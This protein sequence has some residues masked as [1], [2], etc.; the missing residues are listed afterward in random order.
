MGRSTAGGSARPARRYDAADAPARALVQIVAPPVARRGGDRLAGPGLDRAAAGRPG[1]PAPWRRPPASRGR[2]RPLAGRAAPVHDGPARGTARGGVALLLLPADRGPGAGALLRPAVHRALPGLD[3]GGGPWPVGRRAAPGPQRSRAGRAHDRAGAVRLPAGHRPAHGQRER[4]VPGG[5]RPGP[6]GDPGGAPGRN[7][8][9]RRH[10]GRR[11]R[12]RHGDRGQDPPGV[13][14]AVAP[15]PGGPRGSLR[16]LLEDPGGGGGRRAVPPGRERGH[17]GDRPMGGLPRL[18][19]G[20]RGRRGHR[21]PAQRRAGLPAGAAAGP[22]RRG[23]AIAARRRCHRRAR[24]DRRRRPPDP[25]SRRELRLGHRGVPRRPPRHLVPLPGAADPHRRG[26]G[27]AGPRA[28]GGAD[29]ADP[30]RGHRGGG[31]GHRRAGGRVG[32]RGPRPRRGPRVAGRRRGSRSRRSPRSRRR[33]SRGVGPAPRSRA[34][35]AP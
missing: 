34:P 17:R 1:A 22:L 28:R 29:G 25:G 13:A 12:P 18:P 9:C 6:R 14:G 31:G 10:P 21:E 15:G 7:P 33:R 26:R 3:R 16:G 32:V 27:L 11:R 5:D 4:L 8:G 23:R 24:R 19:A 20:E 35:E 30:G 2:R